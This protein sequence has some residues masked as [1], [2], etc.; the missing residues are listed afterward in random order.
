MRSYR[1]SK[2]YRYP[3]YENIMCKH[4]YTIHIAN[5]RPLPT[6]FLS[7]LWL[8][9]VATVGQ[10]NKTTLKKCTQEREGREM[11]VPHLWLA[12]FSFKHSKADSPTRGVIFRLQISPRIRSQNRNGSKVSARDLWGTNFYKNPRK[13]ASLSCP[14]KLQ[15]TVRMLSTSSDLLT[16]ASLAMQSWEPTYTYL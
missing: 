11:R 4:L 7:N 1:S 13:S 8:K 6:L 3:M 15:C 16:T 9:N 5:R 10:Q 14:F 2:H 12:E